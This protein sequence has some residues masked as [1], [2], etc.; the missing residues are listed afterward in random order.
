MTLGI[1]IWDAAAA[2]VGTRFRLHGR[3]AATGLDCIGLACLAHRHAGC[4]VGAVPDRYRLR[5]ALAHDVEAWCRAAG[6]RQ[7]AR[8]AVLPGDTIVARMDAEQWH[9]LIAGPGAVV[10]A[11]A[12]LCRVVMTPVTGALSAAIGAQSLSVR[13][14]DWFAV[15]RHS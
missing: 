15:P 9:V 4:A 12:G 2:L 6:L 7:V 1:R 5:G 11:H 8:N 14:A 10:H 3:D 13:R